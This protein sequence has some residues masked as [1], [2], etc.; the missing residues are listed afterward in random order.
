MH[1]NLGAL[2]LSTGRL[3]EAIEHLEEAVRLKPQ[4]IEARNRL[5]NA[6]VLANRLSEA[7]E[8]YESILRL[9]PGHAQARSGLSDILARQQGSKD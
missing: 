3:T 1:V 2:M 8:Q 4:F 5:G 6:L 7:K 9:D